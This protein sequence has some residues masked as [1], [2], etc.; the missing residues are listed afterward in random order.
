[1]EDEKAFALNLAIYQGADLG[2]YINFMIQFRSSLNALKP[3]DVIALEPIYT[4]D[5]RSRCNSC[6]QILTPEILRSSHLHTLNRRM[7]LTNTWNRRPARERAPLSKPCD[8]DWQTQTVH[9]C[10][11]GLTEHGPQTRPWMKLAQIVLN[12]CNGQKWPIACFKCPNPAPSASVPSIGHRECSVATC[13]IR[14]V[15]RNI[16]TFTPPVPSAEHR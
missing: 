7:R 13:F 14:G 8:C 10:A 3:A 12:G 2:D 6:C 1:M 5:L 16:W 15:F 9:I 11:Q 4:V